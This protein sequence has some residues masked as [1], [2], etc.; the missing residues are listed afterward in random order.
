MINQKTE[1]YATIYD[2]ISNADWNTS[3]LEASLVIC[4]HIMSN[5][6]R[7]KMILIKIIR[8]DFRI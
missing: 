6:S 8:S 1:Y 5:I 4:M 7:I 2:L 3:K